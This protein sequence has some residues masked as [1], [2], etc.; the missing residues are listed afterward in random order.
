MTAGALQIP[1][2]FGHQPGFA[3]VDFLIAGNN[4]E[5]HSQIFQWPN[6]PFFALGL[7]G[8]AGCGKSH[9]AHI[10]CERS[11][12]ALLSATAL[13]CDDVPLLADYP[14]VVI[15]D[16]DQGVDEA[17]LFHL[18]NM[19]RE[20]KRYLLLTGREAPSRWGIVLPDLRSRLSS[21]PVVAI[22]PPDDALLEALLVKLFADRQLRV[23]RDVLA[24]L[25]PR[26][27][28]SFAAARTLV[29]AI[30]AAALAQRREI[31]VALARAVMS[32]ADVD[33]G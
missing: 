12:G 1:L 9:L 20:T 14:A 3:A 5:A 2:D 28:R 16:A 24:F 17:A 30:D 18:F 26:M 31:S 10:H 8:P 19:L 4:S 13:T 29:A 21:I 22:R 27:E 7:W 23:G 25:L 32:V 33:E 11:A 15:E 6:W